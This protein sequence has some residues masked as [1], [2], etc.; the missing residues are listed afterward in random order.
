MKRVLAICLICSLGACATTDSK[1]TSKMTQAKPNSSGYDDLYIS[2]VERQALQRGV[3][4]KWIN[5]PFARKPK[6]T[7]H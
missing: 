2:R 5:P 1:D 3:I 4:V 6:K 7:G